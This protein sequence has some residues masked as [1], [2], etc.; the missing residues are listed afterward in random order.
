[1]GKSC[2]V[3]RTHAST[4]MLH[5][6]RLRIHPHRNRLEVNA[7]VIGQGKDDPETGY[8]E[9]KGS[10]ARIGLWAFGV[11]IRKNEVQ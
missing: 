11:E 10:I 6:Q 1:M 5:H 3:L 8:I 7:V 9:L 2:L 4:S